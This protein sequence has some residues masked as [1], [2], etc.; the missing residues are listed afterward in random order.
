VCINYSNKND[1]DNN[2]NNNNN[3][4]NGNNNNNLRIIQKMPEQHNGTALNQRATENSHIG[5][6]THTLYKVLM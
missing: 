3:N 6:C 1:D 4:N 2:N 5:H